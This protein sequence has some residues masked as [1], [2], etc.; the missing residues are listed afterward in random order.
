M[1]K[2][3]EYI[4]DTNKTI[5]K[6]IPFSSKYFELNEIFIKYNLFE[7]INKTSTITCI[8]NENSILEFLLYSI[9]NLENILFI[10]VGNS[11]LNT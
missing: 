7:N 1:E 9:Y 6:Y 3:Y 11:K 2:A 4:L 5:V 8:S 10:L